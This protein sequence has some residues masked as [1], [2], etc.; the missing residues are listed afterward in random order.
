MAAAT[1]RL[2]RWYS[3]AN[4]GYPSRTFCEVAVSGIPPRSSWR[5]AYTW[6]SYSGGRVHLPTFRLHPVSDLFVHVI[7]GLPSHPGQSDVGVAVREGG[8]GSAPGGGW[9]HGPTV[10]SVL[11]ALSSDLLRSRSTT[12]TKIKRP[13]GRGWDVRHK[14]EEKCKNLME[15]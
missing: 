7:G 4:G 10:R 15:S 2:S 12:A 14:N 5:Q 8:G 1:L 9:G 11:V 3:T 6:W 13:I